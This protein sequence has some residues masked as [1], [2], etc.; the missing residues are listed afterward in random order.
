MN[1]RS[2]PAAALLALFALAACSETQTTGSYDNKVKNDL[3]K[4][5]SIIGDKGG[6]DLLGND[7]KSTGNVSGLAVNGY[8]WRAALDT[9]SFMPLAAADPFGGVLTTDWYA[10]PATPNERLKL[11]VFILDRDLR[12]DGIHVSVFRQTRGADGVWTDAQAAPSLGT[13]LE[14]VILTRARQMKLAQREMQQK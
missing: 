1:F 10:A 4:N 3:Y 13:Q 6:Y 8:L 7:H 9:I 11:N 14:D 5:G 12:A 2:L